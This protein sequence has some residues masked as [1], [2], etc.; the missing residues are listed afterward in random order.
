MQRSRT[1]QDI[2]DYPLRGLTFV[3][4]GK[5]NRGTREDMQYYL[6]SKGARFKKAVTQDV[7]YLISCQRPGGTKQRAAAKWG[8]PIITEDGIQELIGRNQ[9]DLL[10]KEED[11]AQKRADITLDFELFW[12]NEF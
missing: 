9:L 2:I 8:T 11:F 4:T 7:D 5:A 3:V 12:D 10:R 1:E 6:E